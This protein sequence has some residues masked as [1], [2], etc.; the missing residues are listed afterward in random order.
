VTSYKHNGETIGAKNSKKCQV[1]K[2]VRSA[3]LSKHNIR[4][5]EERQG[6]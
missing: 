6:E 4:M 2:R 5:G 1:L 3:L